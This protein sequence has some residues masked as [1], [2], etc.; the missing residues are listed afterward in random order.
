MAIPYQLPGVIIKETTNA[1]AGASLTATENMCLIGLASGGIT[2]TDTLVFAD[3]PGG[4]LTAP[5]SVTATASQ[6]GGFLAA[7]EYFYVVT[8]LSAAGETTPSLE[9]HG[10]I[11]SAIGSILITWAAVPNAIGY[12]VYRGLVT[13]TENVAF[14]VT[15]GL[16]TSFTDQNILTG[17]PDTPPVSNTAT[18]PTQVPVVLPTW[19]A[20][21]NATLGASA[22]ISVTDAINPAV[23]AMDPYIAGTDFT[24][25][26]TAGTITRTSGSRIPETGSVYVT[27]TYLPAGYFEASLHSDIS[28]IQQIYGSAFDATGTVVNSTL[29]FAALCAF[30]N[31][32]QQ[33]Y[34]AP[35]FTL[36][37]ASNPTSTRSQPS[38]S[39]AI[40][41]STSWTQ[42]LNALV[43]IDDI[44]VIT[45]VVGQTSASPGPELT[46]NGLYLILSAVQDWC[47][48][49]L[50]NNQQFVE[51]V[52][53]EDGTAG[54]NGNTNYPDKNVIRNHA[55]SLQSKYGGTMSQNVTFVNST[56][57]LFPMPSALNPIQQLVG[58]QYVA[59]SIAGLLNV[60]SGSVAT[61]INGA[62]VSGFTKVSDF[63]ARTAAD[64]QAD[65]QAGLCVVYS[66]NNSNQVVVRH[67][68]TLDNNS[69]A[70]RELSVVIS[71]FFMI[72]SL[73]NYLRNAIIGKN[74]PAGTSADVY[75]SAAVT[76]VLETLQG[77]GVIAAYNNIVATVA[78]NDPTTVNIAFD[79]T[80]FFPID[81]IN[82]SFTV[83]TTNG[84]VTT[85]GTGA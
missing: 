78:T 34:I 57:F 56:T 59:A 39:D 72:A 45:P 11:T 85:T 14:I 44:G 70:R 60:S 82:I 25:S 29:S 83:D 1:Q 21:P 51:M 40:T 79:Y 58:G 12:V 4:T 32:A 75:V 27:Y 10:T 48:Y 62:A 24:F 74:A 20:N 81:Y 22:I 26:D 31:G 28:V 64:L 15:G 17:S 43:G 42:T 30:N 9:V 77:D 63:P 13:D 16:N 5:G 65:A 46:N 33:V 80:P 50:I 3:G 61:P 54:T 23:T 52:I 49:V 8:A 19:A 37:D 36:A 68:I 35:L 41:A 84:T 47:Y 73:V 53:G 55:L 69:I 6:T 76:A 71:K 66:P 67:A 38:P 2:V 7:T 18:L